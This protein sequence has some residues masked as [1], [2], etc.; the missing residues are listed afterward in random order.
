MDRQWICIRGR[1]LLTTEF[2]H[3]LDSYRCSSALSIR[4]DQ[5]CKQYNAMI[6]VLQELTSDYMEGKNY[7][8]DQLSDFF[9]RCHMELPSERKL[10]EALEE[11]FEQLE[12]KLKID[13][14]EIL[15][16]CVL[17]TNEAY[18]HMQEAQQ[19]EEQRI[20][21]IKS[22][23]EE[24]KL[25]ENND[26]KPENQIRKI[27]LL[28][29]AKIKS[30][31]YEMDKNETN[32]TRV[33]CDLLVSSVFSEEISYGLMLR[34]VENEILTESEITKLLEDKYNIEKDYEWYSEDFIGCGLDELTD[35]KIEDVLYICI[36]RIEKIIG[37]KI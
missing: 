7:I 11:L 26:K 22:L 25:N 30:D 14:T 15:D 35:I 18:A 20:L 27:L 31:Q 3:I 37:T 8:G 36:G 19:Q 21:L 17:C 28:Q 34:L 33:W 9:E 16:R 1:K 4:G 2:I 6:C 10:P 13:F 29:Q 12:S 32:I 5:V 23:M 24:N